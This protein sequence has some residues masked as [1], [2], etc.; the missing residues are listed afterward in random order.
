MVAAVFFNGASRG[1]GGGSLQG[2]GH[3][4]YPGPGREART[5]HAGTETHP[6]QR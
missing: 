4:E 5:P 3:R 2:R 6:L 1:G